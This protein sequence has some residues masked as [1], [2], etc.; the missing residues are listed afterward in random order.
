MKSDAAS[1]RSIFIAGGTGFVG[2]ALIEKCKQLNLDYFYLTRK[3]ELNS[4][5]TFVGD[6]LIPNQTL[7]TCISSANTFINCSGE[8]S[9]TK[10]MRALHVDGT[11]NLLTLLAQSRQENK[12]LFHWIQLSS[13]GAYGHVSSH[14]SVSR[15][16]DENAHDSPSGLYE[17]TKT[18][19]DKLIIEFAKKHNW[20][21]YTIIRPTIVFGIGMRS[22]LIL[23][24]ASM[25]KKKLLV[26][27]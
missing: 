25:I 6:L 17:C 5:I 15:Y 12:I 22:T 8:L 26:N 16:V 18:E 14:P 13:C 10:K 23:R 3:S 19:A 20:F 2:S 1:S 27:L 9:D 24:I 11:Q 21:K 7:S 4:S